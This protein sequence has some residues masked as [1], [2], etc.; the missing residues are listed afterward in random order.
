ME[1]IWIE[2]SCLQGILHILLHQLVLI[3]S[4]G[5]LAHITICNLIFHALVLPLVLIMV[6]I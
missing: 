2:L 5:Y 6:I 3:H 4:Y 1:L